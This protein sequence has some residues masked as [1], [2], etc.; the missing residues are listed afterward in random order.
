M[1]TF[2][3]AVLQAALPDLNTPSTDL[4]WNVSNFTMD[5]TVSVIPEPTALELLT[6]PWQGLKALCK[7]QAEFAEQ[8]PVIATMQT[9]I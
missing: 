5:G 4:M 2:D 1:S 9:G 6:M 8:N 7:M 3:V